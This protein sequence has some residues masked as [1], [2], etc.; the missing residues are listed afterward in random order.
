M[1]SPPGVIVTRNLSKAFGR[2][3]A[4]EHLDLVVQKGEIYGFL[5]PNGA[6][7]STTIRMLLGLMAPTEGEVFVAGHSLARARRKAL[8]H[9][10]AIIEAPAFYDH[11]TARKNLELA[12]RLHG[13]LDPKRIDEVLAF[14]HLSD[15]DE[16]AVGTFSHGMRQRLGIGRAL[17]HRPE[18]VIL[19]EPSDGLDPRGRREV[20]DIILDIS[21]RLE[22]TVLLSSHLLNEM[23]VLCDRI[24]IINQGRL[25]YQGTVA[26]LRS[27]AARTVRIVPEDL[28]AAERILGGLPGV[29][30]V[31]PED[32]ALRVELDDQA[33]ASML[34]RALVEAGTSVREMV[35]VRESLEDVFLRLTAEKPC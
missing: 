17:L 6:G 21:Q 4:V 15:R 10:G 24:G 20:R 3:R 7:K 8:R 32:G 30:R 2:R 19:D 35:P 14:A 23:E 31:Q 12:Q 18:V 5:G 11:L 22:I 34:S 9:V 25:F 13:E 26:D 29:K 1:E 33:D 27:G 16:D 28:A